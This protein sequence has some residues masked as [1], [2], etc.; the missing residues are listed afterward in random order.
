MVSRMNEK[1]ARTEPPKK[2]LK[3]SNHLDIEQRIPKSSSP[4]KTP[5]LRPLSSFYYNADNTP[6]GVT[7]KRLIF[8]DY[9]DL[10]RDSY[11]SMTPSPTDQNF[12]LL[13]QKANRFYQELSASPASIGADCDDDDSYSS[14]DTEQISVKLNFKT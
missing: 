8:D 14:S 9:E 7:N 2:H 10:P 4:C 1:L 12:D 11:R 5:P 6:T 3:K 13:K